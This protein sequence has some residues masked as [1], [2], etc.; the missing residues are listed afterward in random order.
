MKPTVA[1]SSRGTG[2]VALD[3]A[4]LQKL[5]KAGD[6]QQ[7]LLSQYD[8]TRVVA[9]K[10]EK[11]ERIA[12]L[13]ELIHLSVTPDVVAD[14][15]EHVSWTPVRGDKK[16]Q[17]LQRAADIV[18]HRHTFDALPARYGDRMHRL[19]SIATQITG[20]MQELSQAVLDVAKPF[21]RDD[22]APR[23]KIIDIG[24][25]ARQQLA[26]LANPSEAAKPAP[27]AP[28]GPAAGNG[29]EAN[30]G[31]AKP[32]PAR[33]RRE[34]QPKKDDVDEDERRADIPYADHEELEPDEDEDEEDEDEDDDDASM[35]RRRPAKK[36]EAAPQEAV[37]IHQWIAPV[38]APK[39]WPGLLPEEE[40][41]SLALQGLDADK[42]RLGL[43]KII[44]EEETIKKILL[45]VTP[46]DEKRKGKK[47]SDAERQQEIV[48]G[49]CDSLRS[50]RSAKIDVHTYT[51]RDEEHAAAKYELRSMKNYEALLLDIPLGQQK[52]S[53][54]DKA[55]IQAK[56]DGLR[57]L[58]KLVPKDITHQLRTLIEPLENADA[59]L[60]ALHEMAF[61]PDQATAFFR[62]SIE[63]WNTIDPD[64]KLVCWTALRTAHLTYN[65]HKGPFI[66]HMKNAIFDAAKER[67]AAGRHAKQK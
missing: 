54:K 23:L 13:L 7:T 9:L 31:K 4:A 38:R 66:E 17:I 46:I 19:S 8:T 59:A 3:E 67:F 63:N 61:K 29:A 50:F 56:N 64:I 24:T 18:V 53:G 14:M 32:E 30:N 45:Y 1:D 60:D 55:E 35:R 65:P 20:L 42:G 25:E 5:A 21:D 6:E 15:E 11:N 34:R 2:A 39:D 33:R 43:A 52:L 10:N 26:M 41:Y 58:H 22:I 48:E 47:Q 37:K 40:F 44:E 51:S 27:A 49:L 57:P 12:R 62:S 16:A 36:K 28:V